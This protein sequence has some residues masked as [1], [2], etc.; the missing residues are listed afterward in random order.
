M[1]LTGALELS[2]TAADPSPILQTALE[3]SQQKSPESSGEEEEEAV[4]NYQAR[5]RRLIESVDGIPWTDENVNRVLKTIKLTSLQGGQLYRSSHDARS[6]QCDRRTS[7]PTLIKTKDETLQ[8]DN[9]TEIEFF[10]CF[11]DDAIE[12]RM[13]IE[14]LIM[15]R[16]QSFKGVMSED[17]SQLLYHS[18]KTNKNE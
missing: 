4:L 1:D 9:S 10:G 15:S 2:S 17:V 3:R 8:I 16:S 12:N 11:S 6:V 14:E 13:A 5:K 7:D 18:K